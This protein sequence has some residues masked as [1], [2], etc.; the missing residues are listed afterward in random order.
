M[1]LATSTCCLLIRTCKMGQQLPRIL[2]DFLR[3]AA[4]E[5]ACQQGLASHSCISRSRVQCCCCWQAAGQRIM[6]CVSGIRA[7]DAAADMSQPT[8]GCTFLS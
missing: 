4:P 5:P 1:Q 7:P 2:L 3:C 8:N 6:C